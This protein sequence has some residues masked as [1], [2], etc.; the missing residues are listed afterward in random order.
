MK[1][2]AASEREMLLGDSAFKSSL[3]SLFE[4]VDSGVDGRTS[5]GSGTT[6]WRRGITADSQVA[7][8]DRLRGEIS[9]LEELVRT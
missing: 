9:G 5:V 1:A 3:V 4:E 8:R 7:S 2:L 6:Q